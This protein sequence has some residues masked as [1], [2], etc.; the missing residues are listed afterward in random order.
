M[1]LE[2]RQ[3]VM[4]LG[5]EKLAWNGKSLDDHKRLQDE[6]DP[7]RVI[8]GQHPELRKRLKHPWQ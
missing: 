4:E 2:E 5:Q 6:G 3:T 1:T 8:R 7:A